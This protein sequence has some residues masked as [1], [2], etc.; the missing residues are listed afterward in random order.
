MSIWFDVTRIATV[1]NL[2]LL[3]G[4][5]YIWVRNYLRIR[6]KFGLGF[7]AFGGFMLAENGF[8]LYLYVLDPT[9]SSWFAGIPV[10][11][12]VAFMLLALFQLCALS[13]LAWITLE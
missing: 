3:A 10:R 6:T 7:L 5:S 9:T 2:C 4:M 8:A 13:A 1:L 11:Y 12:N